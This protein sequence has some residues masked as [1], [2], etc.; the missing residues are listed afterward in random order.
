MLLDFHHKSETMWLVKNYFCML[1]LEAR[2]S[3]HCN[4][5]LQTFSR[6]DYEDLKLRRRF[7]L[8]WTH[9]ERLDLSISLTLFRSTS[10]RRLENKF[11]FKEF[12]AVFSIRTKLISRAISWRGLLN[13]DTIKIECWLG[14]LLSF[15]ENHVSG[16]FQSFRHRISMEISRNIVDV[17]DIVCSTSFKDHGRKL[18]LDKN[19]SNSNKIMNQFQFNLK[20]HQLIKPEWESF[21]AFFI[22]IPCQDS[23][24]MRK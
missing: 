7:S 19:Y 22:A 8:P 14:I 24:H 5:Y 10:C 23:K 9:L 11:T 12:F 21:R 17:G 6:L 1:Q 20:Y 3:H 4:E 13:W 15:N 18:D 16:F 2:Q